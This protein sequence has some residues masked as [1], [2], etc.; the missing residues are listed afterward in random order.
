MIGSLWSLLGIKPYA[1]LLK[2][3][4]IVY[5]GLADKE[6]DGE[7]SIVKL[8]VDLES[9]L[10]KTISEIEEKTK[11][12]KTK[13]KA[14]DAYYYTTNLLKTKDGFEKL[15]KNSNLD[16]C[17]KCGRQTRNKSQDF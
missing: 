13:L 1:K 3:Y 10:Q 9:E 4:S 2:A 8:D 14:E 12:K 17:K 6:Y 5:Y 11:L 7:S 16:K 15:K